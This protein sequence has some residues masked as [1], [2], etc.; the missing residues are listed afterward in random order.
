M[1]EAV[2]L[3]PDAAGSADPAALLPVVEKAIAAAIRVILGADDACR[4]IADA[5]RSLLELH[6]QVASEARP[7]GSKLA[8]WMIKF[9]F[10]VARTSSP[11]TLPSMPRRWDRTGWRSTEPSW[12]ISPAGFGR[13]R[14][15]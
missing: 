14:P 1:H 7:S 6:V 13:S 4:I 3:L 11:S 10:T 5:I 12:P 2:G 8:S 15:I 9:Q